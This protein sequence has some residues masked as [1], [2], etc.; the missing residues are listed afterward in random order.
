MLRSLLPRADSC[1]VKTLSRYAPN[2]G[3]EGLCQA[4]SARPWEFYFSEKNAC[5][6]KITP[7]DERDFFCPLQVILKLLESL[8]LNS[9]RD[10][11]GGNAL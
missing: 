10:V 9:C 5:P 7:D 8:A 6:T 2:V 3:N 1:Y 11:S 4:E